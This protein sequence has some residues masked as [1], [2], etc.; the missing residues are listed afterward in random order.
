[1]SFD[2]IFNGRKRSHLFWKTASP[3]LDHFTLECLPPLSV[4]VCRTFKVVGESLL[5]GPINSFRRKER[6][7]KVAV[8]AIFMKARLG[9]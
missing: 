8:E 4:L 7:L 2:L 3:S 9:F 1:M 5:S 6:G